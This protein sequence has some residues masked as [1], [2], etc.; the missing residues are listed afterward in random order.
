NASAVQVRSRWVTDTFSRAR[1]GVA[2]AR[3]STSWSIVPASEP[4]PAAISQENCRSSSTC[5][6]ERSRGSARK[7]RRSHVEEDLQ[8]SWEIAAGG[9]SLAGTIDQEV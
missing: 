5:R 1:P 4:P 8:F 2:G 7:R 9:G 3:Y 6:R